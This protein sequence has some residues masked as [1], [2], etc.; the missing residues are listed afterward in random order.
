[1]SKLRGLCRDLSP[2][3]VVKLNFF[4]FFLRYTDLP[5]NVVAR[6]VSLGTFETA[7]VV[8]DVDVVATSTSVLIGACVLRRSRIS[9][10]LSSVS[11]H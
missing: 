7:G 4:S 6:T 1:M 9:G 3:D 11:T 8:V 5:S 2:T 10:K